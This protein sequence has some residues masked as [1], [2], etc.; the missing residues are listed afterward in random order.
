MSSRAEVSGTIGGGPDDRGEYR[1]SATIADSFFHDK[2]KVYANLGMLT[3]SGPTLDPQYD[4]QLGPF[5]SPDS[6]ASYQ[7]GRRRCPQAQSHRREAAME[8]GEQ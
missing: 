1:A 8:F 6:D 4:I 7:L 2:V 3:Q 5:P